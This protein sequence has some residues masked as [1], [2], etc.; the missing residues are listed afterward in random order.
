MIP[1][2][3]SVFMLEYHWNYLSIALLVHVIHY[4]LGCICKLQLA[5]MQRLD[6]VYRD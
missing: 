5:Y 6:S 4:T 3:Y 1:F 2:K